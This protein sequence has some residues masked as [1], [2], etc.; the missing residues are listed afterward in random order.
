MINKVDFSLE[1]KYNAFDRELLALYLPVRHF[2]Y[3]LEA[4]SFIVYTDSS[5]WPCGNQFPSDH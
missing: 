2:R 3:F 4:R 5:T 1:R